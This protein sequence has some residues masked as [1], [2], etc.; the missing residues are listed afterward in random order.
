MPHLFKLKGVEPPSGGKSNSDVFSAK[1]I[2][3]PNSFWAINNYYYWWYKMIKWCIKCQRY[4]VTYI[5]SQSTSREDEQNAQL[6]LFLTFIFI[7]RFQSILQIF[8]FAMIGLNSPPLTSSLQKLSRIHCFL[9]FIDNLLTHDFFFFLYLFIYWQQWQH[10]GSGGMFC[11]SFS[12]LICTFLKRT[13]VHSSNFV[14][15]ETL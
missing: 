11:F 15:V 4:L 1:S 12:V 10:M 2:I 8:Y 14:H 3:L 9:L 6:I 7:Y 13:A 5:E